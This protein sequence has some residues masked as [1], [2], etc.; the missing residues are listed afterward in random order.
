MKTI[1]YI[2]SIV[3]VALFTFTPRSK[4]VELQLYNATYEDTCKID[5]LNQVLSQK[6]NHYESEKMELINL[7]KELGI[8]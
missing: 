6:I 1:G 5:S 4:V 3:T 7:Q 8:R 2:I